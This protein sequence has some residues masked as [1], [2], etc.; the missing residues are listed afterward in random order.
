MFTKG[1]Q[2]FNPTSWSSTILLSFMQKMGKRTFFKYF[3][4]WKI[5]DV[6]EEIILLLLSFSIFEPESFLWVFE[7]CQK[8]HVRHLNFCSKTYITQRI[9][10]RC[11]Y[12]NK[13]FTLVIF[14]STKSALFKPLN[15]C[16]KY[17]L[18][19]SYLYPY[20]FSSPNEYPL[21]A[22]SPELKELLDLLSRLSSASWS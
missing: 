21:L 22:W 13:N 7:W 2:N 12:W 16:L 3:G 9:F 8:C 1:L 14:F 20:L 5:K 17:I 4:H 15:F 19:G 18:N 11:I 6:S 10:F